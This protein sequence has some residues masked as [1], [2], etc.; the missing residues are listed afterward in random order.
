MPKGSLTIK[1]N[2]AEDHSTG[3]D[4]DLDRAVGEIT[5]DDLLA[6]KSIVN[7]ELSEA[8]I[9]NIIQ[10]PKVY[11]KQKRVLGM[12]W[13]P[14]WVHFDLITRR[15][16]T[17]F[18]GKTEELIIPTQH[19]QLLTWGDY[20]GAEIDCYASGFKRKV[21]LLLHFKAE[22]VREAYVLKAMLRH[23]FRYRTS[24]LQNFMAAIL[25][26]V[27]EE[28]LEQA[29]QET[30]ANQKLVEFVRFYTARLRK[31]IDLEEANTPD[32][33]VKNKLLTEFIQ[34][35]A[36]GNPEINPARAVLL[37]K[38]VKKIV[39]RKFSLEYF[40]RA[41][42]VIEEVRSLG[43]GIVIPH[44]EQF[45][46]VLLAGYDVDGFEVWNPQS[47][48]YTEF[49]I[50]AL[51]RQNKDCSRTAKPLLIF[52][53]DDTH[54]SAKIRD[55]ALVERAKV[56]REVGL[57]PPWDE[58]IIRKTLSLANTSRSQVIRDYKDRLD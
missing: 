44:P 34:H 23:T 24:Q 12:H 21:Q 18:P 19:N 9:Q 10:P 3:Q 8:Q 52:M 17:M 46:P 5:E 38:A 31:L 26:P 55:P 54:M 27:G 11:P 43:G 20:S 41:S 15:I 45:W 47:R 40:Y 42:E 22:K 16:E 28:D 25:D 1:A 32:F 35:K 33:M 39:K 36:Q 7:T 50:K 53:G 2:D 57:Q 29:V 14:E 58:L 37:L 51:T 49:L 30:G 13:H 6:Y 56:E 4:F 48:E